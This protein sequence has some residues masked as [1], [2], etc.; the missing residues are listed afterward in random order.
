MKRTFLIAMS[1]ILVVILTV[2]SRTNLTQTSDEVTIVLTETI[3]DT[4]EPTTEP[5]PGLSNPATENATTPETESPTENPTTSPTITFTDV[6]ETVYATGTV[7]V[8]SGPSTD[9]K[10]LGQLKKGDSVKRTGVGDN[11][12]SRVEYEEKTAY[13]FTAYLSTK[14]PTSKK[15]SPNKPT[16]PNAKEEEY[17]GRADT[18]TG[19]SWDGKSPII[20][21]YTDG[22]TGTVPKEGATYESV[23]GIITTYTDYVVGSNATGSVNGVFYCENCGRVCGND[24]S[25]GKCVSWMTGGNHTCPAC[26]ATV[27]GHTCHT[28]KD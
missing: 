1:A 25:N 9:N 16:D 18:E 10:K 22:T 12:W 2:C 13:V 6:N 15:P 23:P 20:Y 28:C 14:N 7:N 3:K 4:T 26:G 5:T 19:I 8:R 11:G 27:P 24:G 17:V 21:T